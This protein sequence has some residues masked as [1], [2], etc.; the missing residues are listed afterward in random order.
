MYRPA[1]KICGVERAEGRRRCI[2]SRL[3][4][5][6]KQL[7]KATSDSIRLENVKTALAEFPKVWDGLEIEERRELL[8]Q[9][10]E[11]LEIGKTQM[12]LKLVLLPEVIVDISS[13]RAKT[14]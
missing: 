4:E 12:T 3:A 8:R 7:A 2:S 13:R 5:I 6:D 9:L 11:R 1:M 10:I 14:E